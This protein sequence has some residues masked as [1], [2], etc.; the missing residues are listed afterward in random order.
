MRGSFLAETTC[1][2]T[3]PIPQ[4]YYQGFFG[5]TAVNPEAAK[6]VNDIEL[7][8]VEFFNMDAHY[9]QENDLEA[10]KKRDYFKFDNIHAM[11]DLD[12]DVI[13]MEASAHDL[14]SM[15]RQM[16]ED[17]EKEIKQDLSNILQTD[18]FEELAY[19]IF[20]QLKGYNNRLSE[21]NKNQKEILK[22]LKE[23][24]KHMQKDESYAELK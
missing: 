17:A 16:K 12:P 18:S 13:A 8:M 2:Q 20:E 4:L 1:F 11:P 23:M 21:F 6:P 24:D 3:E 5:L 10:L 14:L 7:R 15:K 9:Y 22:D 19:K